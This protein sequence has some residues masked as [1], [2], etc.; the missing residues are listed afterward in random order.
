MRTCIRRPCKG[1]MATDGAGMLHQPDCLLPAVRQRRMQG[2][3]NDGATLHTT[4]PHALARSNNLAASNTRHNHAPCQQA[5]AEPSA[6]AR[7]PTAGSAHQGHCVMPAQPKRMP[8][9]RG[10]SM[11]ASGRSGKPQTSRRSRIGCPASS[12]ESASQVPASSSSGGKGP[13]GLG[14]PCVSPTQ[15]PA[16]SRAHHSGSSMLFQDF[17]VP[18]L[19][20]KDRMH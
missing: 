3:K 8:R 2:A 18:A 9:L 12:S 14:A 17:T 10:G 19:A 16:D 13:G 7:P 11:S 15:M 20:C 5:E 6:A 4:P 1:T